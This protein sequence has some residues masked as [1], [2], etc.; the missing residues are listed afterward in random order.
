VFDLEN[1]HKIILRSS[2]LGIY[3]YL[4]AGGEPL[5]FNR[6]LDITKNFPS[7]MFFLF[8]NSILL[9]NNIFDEIGRV[10]NIIPVLST[11]IS[12]LFVTKQRGDGVY[13]SIKNCEEQFMQR[14]IPYGKSVIVNSKNYNHILDDSI[15]NSLFTKMCK[16]VVFLKYVGNDTT[17]MLSSEQSA[18]F[19]R[20]ISSNRSKDSGIVF[21]FPEDEHKYFNKCGKVEALL[22]IAPDGTVEPCPFDKTA[23]GNILQED[24]IKILQ[25]RSRKHDQT[26][27][28]CGEEFSKVV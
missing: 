13:V 27:T 15:R 20:V 25:N 4:L 1:I 19:N 10:S 5:L 17:L 9:D 22:H 21:N 28:M 2:E 26:R 24:L 23:L 14:C 11:D 6:L 16:A 8:T 18:E 12:E 7:Q 3:N